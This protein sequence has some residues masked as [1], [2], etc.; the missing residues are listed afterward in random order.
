VL[1]YSILNHGRVTHRPGLYKAGVSLQG[2]L[3]ISS[4]KCS[5]VVSQGP[6]EKKKQ[7]SINHTREDIGQGCQP[8]GQVE[9]EQ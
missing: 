9:G 3:L 4:I 2:Y 6:G 1:V 5:L 8:A 7:I